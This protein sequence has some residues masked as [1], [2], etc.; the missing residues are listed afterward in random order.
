MPRDLGHR[1]WGRIGR[2]QWVDERRGVGRE[3]L[4]LGEPDRLAPGRVGVGAVAGAGPDDLL[5][6]QHLSRREVRE[7][8]AQGG[9]GGA[10]REAALAVAPGVER[11]LVVGRVELL[12]G[13][14]GREHR[15]GP[16][17]QRGVAGDR[18]SLPG[19]P[20]RHLG[21]G[22]QG[23][24]AG[25][26]DLADVRADLD[27]DP[28]SRAGAVADP[29]VHQ[30]GVPADRDPAS[31][32][33]EVGLG[34]DRVLVVGEL[35]TEVGEQLDQRDPE[36]GRVALFPLRRLRR[37]AV[38]HQPPEALEVAG[39]VADRGLVDGGR[40]A[41]PRCAAVEVARALG[42]EAEV[43]RRE[44]GV[45]A[46]GRLVVGGA[47]DEGQRIDGEV[48]G[49]VDVDCDHVRLVARA[50]RDCQDLDPGDALAAGDADVVGAER[51]AGEVVDQVDEQ[52]LL[53]V[54]LGRRVVVEH[55]DEVDPVECAAAH[56]RASAPVAAEVEHHAPPGRD[57]SAEWRAPVRRMR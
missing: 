37:H 36:V 10:L 15:V 4:D 8:A 20:G 51:R 13:L 9:A 53:A 54:L 39:E 32:G 29:V 21:A 41:D 28:R 16:R 17:Q 5:E 40:R 48:P 52:P 30:T 31:R 22:G 3:G 35:V 12:E 27:L 38:E 49:P 14:P 1:L 47:G 42:L 43:D 46:V 6:D 24:R 2:G 50:D 44:P 7:V 55:L 11:E 34:G 25:R 57:S 45:E 26:Q 56:G 19:E 33:A 18:G 23:R